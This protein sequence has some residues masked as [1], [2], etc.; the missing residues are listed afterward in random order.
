MQEAERRR[1]TPFF[2]R[3]TLD[4]WLVATAYV[5]EVILLCLKMAGKEV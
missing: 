3:V 2:L 1:M 5:N 4:F